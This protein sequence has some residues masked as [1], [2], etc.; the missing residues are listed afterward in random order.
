MTSPLARFFPGI[1]EGEEFR[2]ILRIA[3]KLSYRFNDEADFR[4]FRF[5]LIS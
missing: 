5:S 3:S 2:Y 1:E 4:I